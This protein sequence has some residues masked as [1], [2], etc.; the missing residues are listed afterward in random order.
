MYHSV[1][2]N[3]NE[4][5]ARGFFDIEGTANGSTEIVLDMFN[6]WDGSRIDLVRAYSEGSAIDAFTM[7]EAVY[8]GLSTQLQNRIEGDRRIWFI[9]AQPIADCLPV[10]IQKRNHTIVV[11]NHKETNGGYT[12]VSYEW[13]KNSVLQAG[14][15]WGDYFNET[16]LDTS[17]NYHAIV[18]DTEGI[19]HQTC[20]L[21]PVFLTDF[22]VSVYPVPLQT[23]EYVN[24]KLEGLNWDET[25]IMV[26]DAA[27]SLKNYGRATG[28]IT[29]VE[30]PN[31]PGTYVIKIKS[32]TLMI[33][34]TI[35]RN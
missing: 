12:F 33:E 16:G 31:V 23:K 35:M 13:Y 28:E 10:L 17:A 11:N 7:Q 29:P 8:N 18:I 24:V 21:H 4:Y 32:G 25:E 22:R 14:E 3:S 20:P 6:A 26:Y 19:T 15:T 9:E 34:K 1:I 27:G 30:V 2:D 5:G